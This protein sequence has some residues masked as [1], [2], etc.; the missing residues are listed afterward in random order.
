M[1]VTLDI[2]LWVSGILFALLVALL[3]P[4]YGLRA[5]LKPIASLVKTVDNWLREKGLD[6][7]LARITQ[8]GETSH[9]SLPPEK[10]ARRNQLVEF[11][12]LRGLND[13]EAAELQALLQEDARDDF[14]RGVLG[15]LAF[16]ALIVAIGAIIKSLS[17]SD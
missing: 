15:F 4:V 9:H 7:A 6:K 17:K 13:V 5:D 12:K 16:T 14:T 10:A 2:F 8:Q 11:G 3:V 1:P